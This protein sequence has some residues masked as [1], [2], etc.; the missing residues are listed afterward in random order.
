MPPIRQSV[1]EELIR[2]LVQN[3]GILNCKPYQPM[4]E[5]NADLQEQGLPMKWPPKGKERQPLYNCITNWKRESNRHTY[6][7]LVRRLGLVDPSL[8]TE[9][10]APQQPILPLIQNGG[11]NN[12]DHGGVAGAAANGLQ[13]G[14]AAIN[15][16]QPHQPILPLI[17]NGGGNNGDQGAVPPAAG[18]QGEPPAGQQQQAGAGAPGS[19]QGGQAAPTNAQP[20]QPVL[21]QNGG[22]NNGNQGEPLALQQ[23]QQMAMDIATGL[24]GQAATFHFNYYSCAGSTFNN[25]NITNNHT[26]GNQH[27]VNQGVGVGDHAN[28]NLANPQVQMWI[29]LPARAKLSRG[30]TVFDK[31]KGKLGKVDPSW[32]ENNKTMVLVRYDGEE[33]SQRRK[34]T[35][36]QKWAL[37]NVQGA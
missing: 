3:G 17:Q 28:N 34:R 25:N 35:K 19:L 37:T 2:L 5:E 32:N 24:Q 7:N 13:G 18:Q 31:E 6:L 4:D 23:Q 22:G 36:L 33:E 29:R 8:P 21:I 15:H 30:D 1:K 27:G 10:G 16:A 9:G 14:Q 20:P 26:T 11:G 12:V